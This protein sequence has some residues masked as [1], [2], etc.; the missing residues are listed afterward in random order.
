MICQFGDMFLFDIQ[1]ENIIVHFLLAERH[2][3]MV[4][5]TT[6]IFDSLSILLLSFVIRYFNIA[7]FLW[8]V[9]Y[10]FAKTMPKTQ[11]F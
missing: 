11:I 3:Q 9:L 8:P 6:K 4:N 2:F 1:F 7:N 10:F 5:L